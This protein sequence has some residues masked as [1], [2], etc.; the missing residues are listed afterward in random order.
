MSNSVSGE[1]IGIL[2][3]MDGVIVL[4]NPAHLAAWQVF[5][6]KQLGMEITSETFYRYISGRKNE[7]ALAELLPNRFTPQELASMSLRK[8]AIYREQ[9]GSQLEAVPGVL[10]LIKELTSPPAST[11]M[12][13]AL[14]TSGPPENVEFV[15]HKFGLEK[16]FQVCVNG[17]DV[18]RAKPD[19]AIYLLAAQ[20]LRVPP[21]RCVVLEDARFGV[22]AA[23][24]AG[25]RCLAVATSEP[26]SRLAEAGADLVHQDFRGITWSDLAAV[27]NDD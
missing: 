18:P 11:E 22:Q 20:R 6:R 26:P 9:F 8:E 1:K 3:D 14:A 17:S 13:I 16:A 19:P 2:F 24:R 23:K 21:H 25:M 10:R 15:L 5:G 27:L 4:S 7:D 12:A